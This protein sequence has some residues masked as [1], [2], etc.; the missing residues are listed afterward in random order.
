[1]LGLA[2]EIVQ[3]EGRADRILEQ[4]FARVLTGSKQDADLETRL[5]AMTHKLAGRRARGGTTLA[6]PQ[7]GVP[8][9][10][11]LHQRI[12]DAIED[13]QYTSRPVRSRLVALAATLLVIAAAGLVQ[14]QRTRSEALA[15]AA[16]TIAALN[17]APGAREVGVEGSFLVQF[18]RTPVGTPTLKH[19]PADGTQKLSSWD[20]NRLIVDYTGLRFGVRYEVVLDASYQSKLHE[21]GHFQKRWSFVAEGPPR[22]ARMGPASGASMAPRFGVLSLDFSRRPASDPVVQLQPAATIGPGSWV[23]TT[24]TAHY[25]DLRPLALY[26]AEVTVASTDPVGRIHRT[27][28]FSVEQGPPPPPVPV[29]WYSTS[30]PWQSTSADLNRYVALDWTGKTVGSLYGINLVRQ[31]YDGSWLA[32]TD[33]NV[34]DR[35]GRIVPLSSRTS[36]I[37]S[38]SGSRYCNIGFSAFDGRQWLAAGAAGA[39]PRVIAQLGFPQRG[40]TLLA[41]SDLADRVVLVDQGQTGF[42]DLRVF[43]LSTGRQLIHRS[44]NNGF[45]AVASRDGQYLAETPDSFGQ[46]APTVIRRVSDSAIVARLGDRRVITF[47]WDGSLVLTGPSWN[48]QSAGETQLVNWRTGAVVWRL[49]SDMAN[50]SQPQVFA[51]PQPN[52]PAMMVGVGSSANGPSGLSDGLFLARPDGHA[53]KI[54]TGSVFLAAYA[55]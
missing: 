52:G 23:G 42:M 29:V 7:T 45:S 21:A 5:A 11:D 4:A 32:T 44:T 8:V 3:D 6:L 47:S 25:S 50:G 26:T 54:V 9:S 51:Q 17:P 28:T 37:W 1:V 30:S 40:Y 19:L 22:L 12:L 14:L 20:G 53:E 18:A 55:G 27:W 24:W 33:G 39:N 34:V 49:A 31:N 48:S 13:R 35:S 46:P 36:Q 2:R 43:Q 10:A 16:P 41:C 38:D 15:A